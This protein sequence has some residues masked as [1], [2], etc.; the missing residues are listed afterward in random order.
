MENNVSRF[1]SSMLKGVAIIMMLW[2]HLFL[3][4]SDIGNYTDFNLANGKPLAYFLTRLCTPV[5]FFL[6]LSG[7][8]FAYLYYN[9]RLSPRTQFPRLLKLYIHYWWILL[10]FVPIG[11]FVRPDR[12]P[13]TITDVVLNLLSWSHNYNFET[14]FLLPYALISLTALY[15]LKIINKVGLKPAVATTFLLYL[16]SSYLF[17]RYGSFVYSQLAIALLVEYT[18]F[19]F[20]IVLGVVLFR[21]KFVKQGLSGL[22]VY[23][24]LLFLLI[25]RCLLPTAALD[26]IYS[27]LVI[28]IALRLPMPSIAKRILSY[29]GDYSMIVWLSH[30]FFCYYLFHD[31]IYGFK[32]PLAIFIALMVISLFV[33]IVIRY[34]AKK[35]IEWLRI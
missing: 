23:V 32:Y 29:L 10:I 21:S 31:F 25:L 24:V 9:N 3:K 2:L 6:I 27:F 33:G 14:W 11:M 20:S 16:A 8:G 1:E 4:E 18:Q 15:I 19:L 28:L 5:S 7:Y 12:Y 17:S 35:T 34:L 30:T 13:G 26:P 22:F